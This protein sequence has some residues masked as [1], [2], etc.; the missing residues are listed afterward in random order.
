MAYMTEMKL[1]WHRP[2]SY[3]F[4]ATSNQKHITPRVHYAG[5]RTSKPK[6]GTH[7]DSFQTPKP[8]L[9]KL[10]DYQLGSL[11]TAFSSNLASPLVSQL[12]TTHV[13]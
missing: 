5:L 1:A 11:I 13:R 6:N 8:L 12:I 3:T 7:S 2:S 10:E 9:N 4:Y